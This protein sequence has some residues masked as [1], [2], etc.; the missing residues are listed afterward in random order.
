[1]NSK[2]SHLAVSLLLA[3]SM[4]TAAPAA[5]PLA[6][7]NGVA[8]PQSI[9]DLMIAEQVAQ[10]APNNEELRKAVKEELVRR[11]L[12]TQE[13]KKKGLDKKP[14]MIA[15]MEVA[16]QGILVGG[17]INEWMRANPV[18]EASIRAEYD[19]R[20]VEMS[21]T[22]YKVRHIQLDKEAQAQAIIAKL[23]TGSKFEDLAKESVDAGSKDAGGDIGWVSPKGLPPSLAEIVVKLEKGKFHGSPIQTEYGFHIVKLDDSRQAVPPKYEE[24]QAN[25]RQGLEQQKIAKFINDL[26]SKAKV[27]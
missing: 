12:L 13:A 17:F 10:G 6:K 20:V 15:R 3:S 8:I 26:L 7:V 16:R 21:G 1:M 19:R 25:L 18:T 23:Q 14:E 4:A 11:E 5:K 24:V 2:L 27:E 9:G 22:E